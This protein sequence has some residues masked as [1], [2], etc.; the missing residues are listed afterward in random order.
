MGL[1]FLATSRHPVPGPTRFD[2]EQ[3]ANALCQRARMFVRN[4]TIDWSVDPPALMFD[5]PLDGPEQAVLAAMS[6]D[7]GPATRIVGLA[8]GAP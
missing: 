4:C 7:N 3:R 5:P 2:R 8:K 1:I 6:R